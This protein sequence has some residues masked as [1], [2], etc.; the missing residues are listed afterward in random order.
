[1]LHIDEVEWLGGH[2][3]RLT[4]DNGVEKAVDVSPLLEGP[5]FEPLRDPEIFSQVSIDRV[6]RTVVWPSTADLAPEAFY[7]LATVEVTRR[8]SSSKRSQM[9][10]ISSW[11]G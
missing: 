5:V 4:F 11:L 1:M 8:S 9:S 3:L 6:A 7:A 2:L 10:S